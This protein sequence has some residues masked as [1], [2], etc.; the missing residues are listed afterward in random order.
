MAVSLVPFSYVWFSLISFTSLPSLYLLVSPSLP[1]CVVFVLSEE[2]SMK[3]DEIKEETHVLMVSLASQGHINPLLRLGRRL[4]SKGLHVTLALT[5]VTRHR[6]LKSATTSDCISGIQLEFFSDGF[7]LDY[8]RK[9]HLDHYMETIGKVGP[10][11]LSKLIQD[12]S[13]SGL[14]RFSCLISNPFVPWAADVAAEH[15]IPSAMLWI[16]P[17]TIFSIYYRFYNRLNQFPTPE[18]PRM[19]VELPGL[20]LLGTEDLP[21]FVLPSNPFGSLSKMFSEMFP[22]MEKF[23]WVLGN[24]FH[25]L[26]K[27]VIESMAE[28]CPI[29][30]VG[31]LVPPILMGEVEYPNADIGLELWKPEETCLEWLNKQKPC[32]V[33]YVSFGSLVVLSAKQ[34]ENIAAGLKNSHRPFLWVVKPRDPPAADGSG[35]LPENFL[36]ET[37]DRGLVVP[38]S[39]QAT[40]LTHPSIACFLSHCGWNS[41]LET[42][43]AG[44][45]VIACPQWTDQPTNAKLIVDVLRV[46]V[47][48]RPNQDGIVSGEEVK[49]SIDDIT[50]GARAEEVKKAAAEWKQSAQ[51]AVADGGSSDRNIQW[52]VDEI[53]AHF[54]LNHEN[55]K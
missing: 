50:V 12:R 52:F 51:K 53:K 16:Q 28:L 31:P 46:G 32:S 24:S 15:G 34:M 33:I 11:N 18:N 1:L 21:S 43:S 2:M 37:K 23:K 42:I 54:Q 14:G 27:D 5:E 7:S 20:P 8:D 48:L 47:R 49:K 19:I 36:E 39:P 41:T 4:I 44:V 29:R 38:W 25:E 45:P 9:A 40:V 55:I 30:A 3:V 10:I 35:Q 6:M 13:Q 22:N 26:E 17:S